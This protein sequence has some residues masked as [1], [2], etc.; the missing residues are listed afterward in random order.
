MHAIITGHVVAII[1]RM[2]GA[3]AQN[4]AL[5][6][7]PAGRTKSAYA[8]VEVKSVRNF[9]ANNYFDV[10]RPQVQDTKTETND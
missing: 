7:R 9:L 6:G 4:V 2:R 3:M 10:Y 1:I 5:A 8:C